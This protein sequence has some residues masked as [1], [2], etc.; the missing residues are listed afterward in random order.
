MLLMSV[1]IHFEA[2]DHPCTGSDGLVAKLNQM[3]Q[4]TCMLSEKSGGPPHQISA[5]L[6]VLQKEECI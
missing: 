6:P 2:P 1:V 5:N 4:C 3:G